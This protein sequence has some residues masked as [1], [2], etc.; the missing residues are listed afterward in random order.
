MKKRKYSLQQLTRDCTAFSCWEEFA[1]A[2]DNGYRP[3]LSPFVNGTETEDDLIFNN[4]ISELA[5][6][7]EDLGWSVYR[8]PK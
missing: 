1:E 3:S 7:I 5:D 2:M 4:K 6:T 8:G